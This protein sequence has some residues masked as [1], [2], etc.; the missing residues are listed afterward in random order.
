MEFWTILGISATKDE[1]AIN[2]A[3]REKLQFVHPEEHPEEFMQLRAAYDEA[4][5]YARQSDE[6]DQNREKTPVEL[7]ID[8]VEEVY[9]SLPRRV[10]INEWKA[11][12]D[13]EVCHGLDSRLDA[14]DA[15]LKFGMEC[16][17]LPDYVWQAL[18]D[19]FSFKENRE[20]LY[21]K[22]P[23]DYIDSAV[24]EGTEGDP[25]VPYEL[26]AEGTT[27]NPDSYIR[28][29]IKARNERRNRELDAS[30]ATIEDMKKSGFEHPYTLLAQA[31]LHYIR[32]EDETAW[33]MTE[34]L[35]AQY[36]Q[37]ITI[38][39]V[40]G[41]IARN[42]KKDYEASLADYQLVLDKYESHNQAMWGKAE[43]LFALDKLED[44][45]DIYLKLH[46]RIPFDD[47][48][49]KR[50]E[51]VNQKLV[52]RYEQSIADNPDDFELRMDYAWSCL[53]RREHDKA[54]E[55]I[56]GLE[57]T[58]TAQKA[59]LENF[60]TKLCLNCDEYEE[61]L[62]HAQEWEKLIPLLP[63]GE[64]DIEKK[65]KGKLPEILYLQ[66]AALCALE[67]YDE[68]IETANRAEAADPEKVDPYD[69]RRRA[70]FRRREYDKAVA[71]AEK[72]VEMEPSYVHWF[73]LGYDQ[74]AAG[75]KAAAY[76][77]FGEALNYG[78]VLQAYIY[79]V[80]I[81][82]DFDEWEGVKNSIEYLEENGVDG[83]QDVMRYLK[84]RVLHS[85][86]K[87]DE[88]LAIY[89]EL[90][91]KIEADDSQIDFAWEVYHKVADIE[92]D[93]GTAPEDV[94]MIVDKGLEAKDDDLAL[95]DLKSYLL[96]KAKRPD[97]QMELNKRIL[98]LYPNHR[99][100]NERIG[101]VLYD[102]H[103]DYAGALKYYLRQEQL[104]DSGILQEI[105]G[106]CLMY[107]ER[108][109]E[110]EPHF[111]KA[112]EME[113]ERL[114]PRTNLGLLYERQFDFEKSLPHQKECVR[115]CEEKDQ[116]DKRCYRWL[117]RTLA[118]LRRYDESMDAYRKNLEL[119]G[120]DEDAR[121]VVEVCMESGRFDMADKL[122]EQ[123]HAE[124]KITDKYLPMKADITKLRG[125][126]F[127]KYVKKMEDGAEKYH[128]LADIYY[129]QG[130]YL[131]AL[132][133]FEKLDEV[134]PDTAAYSTNY[135]KCL[136]ELGRKADRQRLTERNLRE[137]AYME[138]EGWRLA[139][140][141]THK[142][143]VMLANDQPE[144]AKPL[145]DRALT[146]PM[147]DHCRYSKCK[148]AIGALALYY[149][150]TGRLKEA[151][152]AY[153][154]AIEIAPD[155]LDFAEDIKRV[156]K[157]IKRK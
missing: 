37:D 129:A 157:E 14:R 49:S 41:E 59:D 15:F 78:R 16:F 47:S 117:A 154:E 89:K 108:Y 4:L 57:P 146:M 140:Y 99:A 66:A 105:I 2:A 118:R 142:A 127:I 26:F 19:E 101:D 149:E 10:D 33:K 3:Y 62:R 12:L 150:R 48:I 17:Y 77:S 11:L 134:E 96:W 73:A 23:R 114:R 85:E 94:L 139:L 18:E 116:K 110:A 111:V 143:F 68:C 6:D 152:E 75:N 40:H 69:I 80:R 83:N 121:H 31:E 125:K 39:L 28:L 61:G 64:T 104:R 34:E 106:L 7:W 1:E 98:E 50:I 84:A 145:I 144:E 138:K 38:R 70:Y 63:E 109:E 141:I 5:K 54:K 72:M 58:E 131:K 103:R 46:Q 60:S 45:K 22:F 120:E 9:N 81:L 107:L 51:E 55:L 87:K 79:R 29:Y 95:L 43:C 92:D 53:Q 102:E 112:I 27:G 100:A 82:C 136:R 44:A 124:G 126:S 137:C 42:Y 90:V 91:R 133:L 115:I 56:A 135:I 8:K 65:R 122:L 151:L 74:Y 147:C 52:E 24:I 123:Y 36:P 86:D 148:D 32:D 153:R 35:L 67:R 76:H 20:E 119:Y 156:E 13:D 130:K 30:A 21:E 132:E 155:D 128:R 88:A 25:V 93:N 71:E 97:E 113:P